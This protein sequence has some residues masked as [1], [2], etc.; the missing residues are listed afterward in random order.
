MVGA[1]R[2]PRASPSDEEIAAA[3][4]TRLA[5]GADRRQA[6]AGVARRPAGLRGAVCIDARPCRETTRPP[7]RQPVPSMAVARFYVTTPIYYVNDAPHIGHAYTT[8]T[9]DALARWHRLRGDDVFFLTGTDEHGLKV[10]RAAEAN[11]LDPAGAG[12]PDQRPATA[13]RG[14][15]STS[16]TTISSARPKPRHHRA[17]AGPDAGR[18][19]QRL[20]RA[21]TLRGPLLRLLRGLLHR[22]GAAGRD[23]V[24]DPRHARS[25]CWPRRT[26]SSS[27]PSSPTRCSSGTRPIPGR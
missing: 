21:A 10:Q 22:V 17:T 14:P 1:R 15:S 25:S 16:P 5:A 18:L 3:L 9:A 24:P 2:G 7:E 12:R 11:G 23:A 27:C 6:V 26:T 20:D 8:V 4:Q 13:R 19:R